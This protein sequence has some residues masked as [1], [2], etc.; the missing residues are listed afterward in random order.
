MTPPTD[1]APVPRSIDRVRADIADIVAYDPTI[2][3][4]SAARRSARTASGRASQF[5]R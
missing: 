4:G 5:A 2:D 3:R 1:F